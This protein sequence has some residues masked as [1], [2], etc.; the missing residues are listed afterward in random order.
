MTSSLSV[1][2][3]VVVMACFSFSP[4]GRTSTICPDVAWGIAIGNLLSGFL[5]FGSVIERAAV[6]RP[7]P[8]EN[9]EEQ[10]PH[11]LER[12]NLVVDGGDFRLGT[13]PNLDLAFVRSER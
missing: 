5:F 7:T 3:S 12:A 4:R 11:V 6:G 2:T 1:L 9:G 10:A 13:P 8:F